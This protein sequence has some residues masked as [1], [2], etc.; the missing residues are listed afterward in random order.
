MSRAMKLLWPAAL[1]FLVGFLGWLYIK[2]LPPKS[3]NP[4][5][6]TMDET[7]IL[8]TS[9]SVPRPSPTPQ[10]T[11]SPTPVLPASYTIFG[12]PF[13]PQAPFANWDELHNEA[14]EEAAVLMVRRYFEGERGGRIDPTQADQE[15]YEI[16]EWEE[17]NLGKYLDTNAEETTQILTGKYGLK[18]KISTAVN[19]ETIKK[20]IAA[21]HLVIV[22]AAGRE[23]PNPYFRQPGPAYHMLV[24][25]GYN[26]KEF[27]TNDPGTKRGEGFRYK[28]NDLINAVHDWTG[29]KETMT[30]GRKVMIVV[31]G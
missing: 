31:E 6:P 4:S 5:Q 24:I 17:V 19:I 23:L 22:P 20:E 10:P 13:T 16:V 3:W 12:V 21:N 2:N 8:Q 25:V 1:G 29:D 14:C 27:I 9:L 15:I 28:Y 7:P 11:V 18:T 26:E 30:S